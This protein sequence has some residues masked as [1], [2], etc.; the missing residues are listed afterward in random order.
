MQ[1]YHLVA[2]VH[3]LQLLS[4][5]ILDLANLPLELCLSEFHL[6]LLLGGVEVDGMESTVKDCLGCLTTQVQLQHTKFGR[7]KKGNSSGR[8]I[9]VS[10]LQKIVLL[11]CRQDSLGAQ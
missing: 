3:F 10:K 11:P 7:F 4:A 5:S 6:Q 2:A 1:A 8:D 9:S